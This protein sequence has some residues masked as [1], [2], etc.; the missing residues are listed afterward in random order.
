MGLDFR[1][2]GIVNRG[3]P[4]VRLIH[5]LREFNREHSCDVAAIAL[6]TLAER[7]ALFV[8]E[9]DGAFCLDDFRAGSD[10]GGSPYLD[11]DLLLRALTAARVDA[12]WPGWGFVAEDADFAD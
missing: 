11:H 7:R 2:V 12:V 5:A 9:A 1:R 6:H 4:A 3:E 10:G 8:R